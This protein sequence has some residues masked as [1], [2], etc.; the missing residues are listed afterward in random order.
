MY[1]KFEIEDLRERAIIC[2]MVAPNKYWDSKPS[3]LC[4]ICNGVGRESAPE[5]VRS[6]LN[7]YFRSIEAAA[8]IHDYMYQHSD[9]TYQSRLYADCLFLENGFKEISY[10]HKYFSPFKYIAFVKA[11]AAFCAIRWRGN[12]TWDKLTK[13]P[14]KGV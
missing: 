1:D 13:K 8:T 3:T 9:G 12:T 4:K 6:I 10:N 11:F 14:K 5:W 7:S 2:N